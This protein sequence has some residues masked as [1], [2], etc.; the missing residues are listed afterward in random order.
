MNLRG[1]D[2]GVGAVASTPTITGVDF[3]YAAVCR[4]R[5][6]TLPTRVDLLLKSGGQVPAATVDAGS[7]TVLPFAEPDSLSRNP[8]TTS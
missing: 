2:G 3:V 4:K 7:T 8:T 1:P 5:I 6:F